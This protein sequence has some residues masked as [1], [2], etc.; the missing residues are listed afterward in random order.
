MRRAHPW[1]LAAAALSCTADANPPQRPRFVILGFDGFDP[2]IASELMAAGEL[3]HLADLARAG[4]FM[5]LG[6]STPPQSPVAWSEVITGAGAGVH[7]V[8]DFIH[9]DPAT[10]TPYLSTARVA[11]PEHVDV[12]P[13]R[14]PTGGGGVELLRRAPAF[15]TELSALGV[16]VRVLKLPAN[17]PPEHAGGAHAV[18]GMGTPDLLGTYGT[19]TLLTSAGDA[20]EVPGGRFVG[21]SPD[22][23]GWHAAELTGPVHPWRSDGR[24]LSVPV[25]VLADERTGAAVVDVG[26]RKV[27]LTQGEW[28]GWITV[29]FPTLPLGASSVRGMVRA[30]LQSAGPDDVRVYLSPINIDPRNPALPISEPA[31]WAAELAAAAGPFHSQGMPEDTKG[32][33]ARALDKPDFLAQGRAIFDERRRLLRATLDGFDGGL[34]FAYFSSSDPHAHV[35]WE[36]QSVV[37]DIYGKLDRVVGEVRAGLDAGDA[38]VVM[39]DHGF[40]PFDWEVDL[41]GWLWRQGYLALRDHPVEGALGHIDWPRTQAYALGF[42]GLYLNQ[43]G[44]EAQGAVPAQRRERMLAELEE[45]LLALRHLK[46]GAPVVRRVFRTRDIAPG[47]HADL[48]PDLV[49]GYHRGYRSSSDSALGKVRD[50][51]V[52]ANTARWNGDHCMDPAVVPGVLFS[53][54]PVTLE[55][56]GLK[57]LAPTVLE[58]FGVR[59]P[60]RLQGRALWTHDEA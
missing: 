39:S 50:Q 35:L 22:S 19:F 5:P 11:A 4:T 6:T 15:W 23:D 29:E 56:P 55:A 16:P 44:R 30:Q 59:P 25:R 9:R 32:Y 34:L 57:D 8:H 26:G 46:T 20:R 12:G 17:F 3:P 13:L 42:N 54:R 27:L 36:D 37:R 7:G 43:A 38:L 60:G 40:S 10:Y 48:G 28:S 45:E 41:N 53:N 1:L 58:F 52:T 24:P 33:E 49:V 31:D 2:L 47:P 18:S 21:L 14:V 51:V